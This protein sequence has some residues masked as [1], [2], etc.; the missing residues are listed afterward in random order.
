[1]HS[2]IFAAGA[3][4]P[5]VLIAYQPK[6]VG[7]MAYFG[8]TDYVVAIEDI[9]NQE[10]TSLIS[11]ELSARGDLIPLI[12]SRYAEMHNRVLSINS[13]LTDILC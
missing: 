10:L 2:A 8:S 11:K 1:M 3:G 5:I 13:Y 7:T 6:A 12:R 9:S 4:V